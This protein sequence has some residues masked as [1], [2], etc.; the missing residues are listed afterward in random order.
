MGKTGGCL[1]ECRKFLSTQNE[2]YRTRRARGEFPLVN[3][4]RMVSLSRADIKKCMSTI[5]INSNK[6]KNVSP[7][8]LGQPLIYLGK[9]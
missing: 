2:Q 4:S 9:H 6:T 5:I 7:N 8:I 1:W 3:R